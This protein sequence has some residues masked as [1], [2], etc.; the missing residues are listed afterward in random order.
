MVLVPKHSH[1]CSSYRGSQLYPGPWRIFGKPTGEGLIQLN[2]FKVH[3]CENIPPRRKYFLQSTSPL[4][5]YTP[6]HLT[7]FLTLQGRVSVLRTHPSPFTLL[8]GSEG[9]LLS[10]GEKVHTLIY[11]SFS[12]VC[13]TP[14]T[15]GVRSSSVLNWLPTSAS[16]FIKSREWPLKAFAT[17]GVLNLSLGQ[18]GPPLPGR[19]L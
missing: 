2:L 12:D 13:R 1:R 8:K 11:L 7:V 16:P 3:Y 15:Q 6:P 10:T 19:F 5:T 17:H 4:L 18:K 14:A 9:S